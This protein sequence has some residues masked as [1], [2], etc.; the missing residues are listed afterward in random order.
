M[1]SGAPTADALLNVFHGFPPSFNMAALTLT[2]IVLLH[3]S[4]HMAHTNISNDLTN[5]HSTHFH[6]DKELLNHYRFGV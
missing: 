6:F 1:C 5:L 2:F 4:N 3:N